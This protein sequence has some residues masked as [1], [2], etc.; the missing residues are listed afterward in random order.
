MKVD[1]TLTT[2]E[3]LSMIKTKYGRVSAALLTVL[4][5]STNAIKVN[6]AEYIARIGHLESE[7]QP[8]HQALEEVAEVIYERTDGAVEIKIFPSSQLGDQRQ[9]T[10]GVQFGAIQGTVAPAAFLGGFNPVVSILDIPFLYPAD[11]E[12]SQQIRNSEF[13]EELLNSFSEK[14]VKAIALWP[15]GRKSF[16]SNEPLDSLHSFEGQRFRTMNSKVL[17]EQFNALGASAISLPFG[18]LYTALQHGVVDGQENPLDTIQ[19][20]KF[21]E[22]Q[23]YLLLSEH[24]VMEDVVLFSMF[25]WDT[26][27]EN[28]KDVIVEAFNEAVPVVESV[29]E[30]AQIEAL[31]EVKDNGM[32]VYEMSESEQ[33]QFREEVYPSARRAYLEFAGQSGEDLLALYEGVYSQVVRE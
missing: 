8:R 20:M 4:C 30:A 9:M 21:Y 17:I 26:L 13:G 2:M 5:M 7:A 29:K 6:A 3:N 22:V 24:G 18:E 25:W 23:D 31:S 27:P 12:V 19:L 32:V 16:T 11:R 1:A 15:N 33:A 14:G 10:E 28:Y